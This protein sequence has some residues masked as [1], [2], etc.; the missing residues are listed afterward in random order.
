MK[1][2]LWATLSANGSYAR[3]D[4]AHPP[5]AEAL[6]DFAAHVRETRSFVVGRRTFESFRAASAAPAASGAPGG[7]DAAAAPGGADAS[8][9]PGGADAPAAPAGAAAPRADALGAPDIVVVSR[10]L[11]APGLTVVPG[12][13]E[14]LAALAARGHAS[15][16][17]AGG[18]ALHRAFLAADLVDELVVVV[19]PRLEDDALA[20]ALPAGAYRAARHL[21]TTA[22]GSGVVRLRYALR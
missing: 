10:T 15:T 16:L 18:A 7:A 20:I 5:F 2:I 3:N 14:A 12:P 19:A 13:A 1:T 9:A 22:L 21:E 4:P 6:A 17:V 8:D 11:A